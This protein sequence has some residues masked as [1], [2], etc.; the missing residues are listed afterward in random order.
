MV[1]H[2]VRGSY[3]CVVGIQVN[4]GGIGCMATR[5]I[6]EEVKHHNPQQNWYTVLSIEGGDVDRA[7]KLPFS[8]FGVG[9]VRQ[10]HG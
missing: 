3:P 4:C 7:L 9:V 8:A 2:E 1:S 5:G 10:E 6:W